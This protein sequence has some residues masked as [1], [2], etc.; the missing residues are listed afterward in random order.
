MRFFKCLI[1][2]LFF[3]NTLV[4]SND[5]RISEGENR[6]NVLNKEK[7]SFKVVN[8]INVINTNKIKT[9]LG[10]FI[11]LTIPYYSTNSE[12]GNP[13][14]PSISKLI[15]VPDNSDIEI[16]VL[17]KV[18]KKIILSEYNIKNQIFP[19]QPSI[20]KSALP[21][22]IKFYINDNVYKKNDFINE[23]IF[24]T[25]MLGKMR[26]VQLARLIISP[27][28]YNPVKQELE[29]ITSLELEVKFI[30][31]KNSNLNS[32]YYSSEFDH[33]YKKCI[34]YLPPSPEDIITTYPTKYVIVSDPLFQSSLQPF[35]E[36]KTKKGFQI[37]EAYTN[38][39]NVGTTT[40]SIK[41][42]FL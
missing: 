41:S 7:N 21:E 20:S 15:S 40:S 13:E 8:Q 3:V 14:L 11:K 1:F 10:D 27:F 19:H 17:N 30:S 36:W 38:D 6:F 31:E 42:S 28:S 16:K 37:I 39:P 5:I 9:E 4:F 35:I 29:I 23:K 32:S 2:F 12:I 33:L 22:E 18:S 26:E 34:N 24:K 25:E